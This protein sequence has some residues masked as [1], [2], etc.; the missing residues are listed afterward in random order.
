MHRIFYRWLAL[1]L[2]LTMSGLYWLYGDRFNFSRSQA[3][4]LPTLGALIN[5]TTVSGISAGAYMAGQFQMAHGRDVVGAALIAG[6]PYGCAQSAFAGFSPRS[7]AAMLSA[8][9]AVNG[10]M[11]NAMSVWGVPNP[12]RLANKAQRLAHEQ[13]IDPIADVTSDRIYLFS[14]RNDHTVVPQIV[15]AA[16]DY[17]RALGVAAEQI[18]FVRNVGAGHG[19]IVEEA[20]ASCSYSGPPYV[21]DCDYDQAGALLKTL[22]G[23]LNEPS[24]EMQGEYVMFDQRPFTQGLDPTSLSS[25]GVVYVPNDCRDRPGCRIHIVFHGCAQNQST[26]GD[27]FVKGSGFSRWAD[28]NRIIVLFPQVQAGPLNPGGCWDW[29]GYTGANYLTKDAPQIKT[30]RR[31]LE[32]LADQQGSS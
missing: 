14:G 16:R 21:V 22:Y 9:R 18:S 23:S 4:P 1:A 29:W 2:L 3:Q 20:N 28:T 26:V 5:Q 32:V 24:D 15:E 7:G 30:V 10:C 13:K 27:A 17:Y 11:L 25:D 31:M 19:F 12:Q 6:G 8:T